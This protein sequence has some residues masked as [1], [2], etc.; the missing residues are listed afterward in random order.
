MNLLNNAFEYT[1]PGGQVI[2]QVRISGGRVLISVEDQCGGLPPNGRD[3][4]EP[5]GDRRGKD[6]TGL[7]LGL[8]IA[9]KAVRSHGGD[10]HIQNTPGTG[11]AFIIDL[12][13]ATG[14]TPG[15]FAAI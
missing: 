13:L 6:R 4:F 8:S 12:P 15:S 5:F 3:P 1:R 14:V 10:I 11:C 9:R 7:G 2:L